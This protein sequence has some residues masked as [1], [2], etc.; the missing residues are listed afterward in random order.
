MLAVERKNK[1]Y[2]PF[3]IKAIKIKNTEGEMICKKMRGT[4]KRRKKKIGKPTKEKAAR[5]RKM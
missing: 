4:K 3:N 5:C 2:E 1:K